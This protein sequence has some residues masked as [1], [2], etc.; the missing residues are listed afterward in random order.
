MSKVIVSPGSRTL[1]MLLEKESVLCVGD[2]AT[3]L[4]VAP[5]VWDVSTFRGIDVVVAA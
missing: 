4:I 5:L 1:L 3:A 2:V